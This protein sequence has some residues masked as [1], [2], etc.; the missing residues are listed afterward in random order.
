MKSKKYC[1]HKNTHQY[2]DERGTRKHCL[3]CRE[4]IDLDDERADMIFRTVCGI[5]AVIVLA[6]AFSTMSYIYF[7]S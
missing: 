1:P 3:D 5:V 4:R 2:T 6:I 7:M